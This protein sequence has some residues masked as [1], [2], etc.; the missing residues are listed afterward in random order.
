MYA[1]SEDSYVK[2]A[3]FFDLIIEDYHK[4]KKTDKHVSDM[5]AS[6]LNAPPFSAEDAAFIKSTRIRVGRNL[7]GYP[8]GPGISNE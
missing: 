1:G 7:K 4:H 6:H 2:F 3:D 8:L 5:D